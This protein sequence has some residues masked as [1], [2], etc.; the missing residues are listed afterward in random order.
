[1]SAKQFRALHTNAATDSTRVL[2]HHSGDVVEFSEDIHTV[3]S[4]FPHTQWDVREP[5]PQVQFD[6]GLI[7]TLFVGPGRSCAT[8]WECDCP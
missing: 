5:L 7:L 4:A 3:G 8:A 1:V 2:I 6:G